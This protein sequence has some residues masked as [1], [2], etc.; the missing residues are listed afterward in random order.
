[1]SKPGVLRSNPRS[2][3]S[4]AAATYTGCAAW[5]LIARV[6]ALD[7]ADHCGVVTDTAVE[8]EMALVHAATPMRVVL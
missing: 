6:E 1:M 5:R 8:E 2:H 4:N 7:L 3:V